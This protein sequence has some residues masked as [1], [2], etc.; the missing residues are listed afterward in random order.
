MQFISVRKKEKKKKKILIKVKP[1][2][3]YLE[4]KYLYPL[5]K[6]GLRDCGKGS[7]STCR[8]NNNIIGH[9]S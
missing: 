5:P 3:T 9:K 8:Q 2:W 7:F 1:I 6:N 4:R